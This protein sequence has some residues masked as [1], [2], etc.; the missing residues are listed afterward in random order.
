MRNAERDAHKAGATAALFVAEAAKV[1]E[2][3][4]FNRL[5]GQE[6]MSPDVMAATD[7][8]A[9]LIR[10]NTHSNLCV[11][12]ETMIVSLAS[13]CVRMAML[14]GATGEEVRNFA[15]DFGNELIDK[16]DKM[17]AADG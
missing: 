14:F 9:K 2:A 5:S 6:A 8:L 7:A 4:S 17:D 16:I 13:I 3:A 15:T 12:D 1:V 11:H 10:D